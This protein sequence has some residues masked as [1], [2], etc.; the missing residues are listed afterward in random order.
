MWIRHQNK[1]MIYNIVNEIYV[2]S[3]ND[4]KYAVYSNDYALGVYSTEEKAMKVLDMI[5]KQII[6][7]G[8]IY[9]HSTSGSGVRDYNV[10]QMPKDEEV[11]E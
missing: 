7:N 2:S 5:E 11:S 10:F 1:K 3:Y 9:A 8:T 4:T 6:S